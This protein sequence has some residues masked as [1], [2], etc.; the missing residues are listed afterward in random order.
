MNSLDEYIMQ[1][2]FNTEVV[3][4][5]PKDWNYKK[6]KYIKFKEG[7][8]ALLYDSRFKYFKGKLMKSWLGPYNIEKFYDNGSF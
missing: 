7:D 1:E 6:I 8:W 5:Q 2:V 3:Q 4:Q